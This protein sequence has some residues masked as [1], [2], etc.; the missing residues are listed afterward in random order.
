ME[1]KTYGATA[2]VDYGDDDH[3]SV[4]SNTRRFR[5]PMFRGRANRGG[6]SNQ[7]QRN[8]H[9]DTLTDDLSSTSFDH[10]SV[11]P[12]ESDEKKLLDLEMII[13]LCV[14]KLSLPPEVDSKVCASPDEDVQCEETGLLQESAKSTKRENGRL[15]GAFKYFS[16]GAKAISKGAK[17]VGSSAVTMAKD[18]ASL[19]LSTKSTEDTELL[20]P[21]SQNC[22]SR[23]LQGMGSL[24]T[25]VLYPI[26]LFWGYMIFRVALVPVCLVLFWM[27]GLI[28]ILTVFKYLKPLQDLILPYLALGLSIVAV[29]VQSWIVA[30]PIAAGLAKLLSQLQDIITVAFDDMVNEVPSKIAKLLMALKIPARAADNLCRVLF[31]PFREVLQTIYKILPRVDDLVPPQV[32]DPKPLVPI[33]FLCLLVALFFGQLL[34][35]LAMGSMVGGTV[36]IVLGVAV[37]AVLGLLAFVAGRI[38]PALLGL[39][40]IVV[41]TVIQSLLR[42]M[43]PVAKLQESIDFVER[44]IPKPSKRKNKK[45]VSAKSNAEIV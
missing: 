39:V 8:G 27:F 40:E 35:V 15:K 36:E 43:L 19:L 22:L 14:I 5:S 31:A 3:R 32:K 11:F 25:P 2:S 33:V 13:G 45:K 17:T 9:A 29:V 20:A 28:I 26:R 12:E 21:K 42:K 24:C 1:H 10:G 7:Y 23:C 18:R 34:L 16:K 41:N 4:S 44:F 6:E 30:L 38:V 37:C